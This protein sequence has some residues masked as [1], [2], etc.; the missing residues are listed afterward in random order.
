MSDGDTV[1]F[2]MRLLGGVRAAAI[3]PYYNY[4]GLSSCIISKLWEG[5][6]S[7]TSLT[8]RGWALD[9]VYDLRQMRC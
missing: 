9:G 6:D 5:G 4:I 2:Y 3:G 7:V 1:H 8:Q